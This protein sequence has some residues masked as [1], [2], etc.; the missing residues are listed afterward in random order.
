MKRVMKF[1]I[2]FVVLVGGGM[3]YAIWAL[4]P[5]LALWG[6]WLLAG[7]AA[8]IALCA[9]WWGLPKWQMRS[10]TNEDL[11]EKGRAGIEND[12]RVTVGQLLGGAALLIGAAFAYVQFTTQRQQFEEQQKAARD[13]LISNQVAKGFELLG[14]KDNQIQSGSAASTRSKA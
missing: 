4:S 6:D 8:V 11:K 10:V 5:L 7:M 1:L 12:F 3:A 13:L 14:N 2:F 9:L